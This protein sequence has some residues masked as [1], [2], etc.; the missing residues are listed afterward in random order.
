METLNVRASGWHSVVCGL[1]NWV[2]G[3]ELQVQLCVTSVIRCNEV[4]KSMDCW[5]LCCIPSNFRARPARI[6]CHSLY[7]VQQRHL[8]IRT[9]DLVSSRV[10]SL[11][12]KRLLKAP[13]YTPPFCVCLKEWCLAHRSFSPHM[14]GF[15]LHSH[16]LASALAP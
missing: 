11:W 8:P 16:S 3:R 4:R 9:E 12:H 6:H 1:N 14:F 7:A 5:R 15:G 2:D 10:H 13:D